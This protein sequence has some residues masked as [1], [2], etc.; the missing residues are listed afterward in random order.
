MENKLVV[1]GIPNC[2]TIKKTLDWLK[3]NGVS[4][5]FH[6]YKKQGISE[7]QLHHWLTQYPHDILINR[8]G[9]TWRSLTD[10]QKA[11]LTT[12]EAA[13]ALMAS[14]P[15]LIK[16]PIV[17]QNDTIIAVGFDVNVYNQLTL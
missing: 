3:N 5:Y 16:R 14:N 15:S 10:D 4:Y 11:S 12:N 8:K 1:F 9:T 6:D 17:M 2:D 7:T 13:A